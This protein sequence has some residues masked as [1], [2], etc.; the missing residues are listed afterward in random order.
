MTDK[1]PDTP[2]K[3]NSLLLYGDYANYITSLNLTERGKL[4]TALLC[5]ARDGL[6]T[7]ETAELCKKSMTELVFRVITAQADRERQRYEKVCEQNKT[8]ARNRWRKDVG[9]DMRSHAT[10]C[11][12]DANACHTDTDTDTDP[13]TDPET[14]KE[15]ETDTDPSLYAAG[16]G[17]SAD[18]KTPFWGTGAKR[19]APYYGRRS[20][21]KDKYADGNAASFNIHDA[22]ARALER[23][24]GTGGEGQSP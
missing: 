16:G 8:N 19:S 9:S 20:R 10:A 11:E 12:N 3:K 7:Q 14:E 13:D 2:P 4:L 15:T 18:K 6:N 23:S 5:Y 24:Y 21:T 1:T 17:K 22:F